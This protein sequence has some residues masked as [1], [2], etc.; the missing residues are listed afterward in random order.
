MWIGGLAE[1]QSLMGGLLGS[2]FEYVFRTQMEAL[3][4]GDRLYYLPRIEGTDYEESLQDSS[5]AQLIRANTGI[6]HLPG[7]IFTTPEYTIE[8]SNYYVKNADGSVKLDA[9]GNPT[10]LTKA[11]GS[12]DTTNWLK[13]P[14]TGKLMVTVDGT[15]T[16]VFLGDDNFLGN[17]IVLGG[18]AGNDKLTA[19]PSDADTVWGDGGNDV[20]DGG[21][22]ADFLFGGD[23]NDTLIGGQG[24]DTLH[25]D[26]GNDTIYGG[27][28]IDTIF[29]GDGN[30]YIE[31]GRGDDAIL[32]GLGNDIIIGNEG[33]DA[34]T[35]NEGDDWLE[36]RGGQGQLMFGDS[37]APTGQQPLYSG[38]DVMVGGIAGGDIMKGFSGDDIMLGHGSFTKFIGG[39]GFDWGSY[40]LATQGVDEDMN[41]KEFVAVNG[42]VDNVRDVWQATEGASGSAFNDNI[43]G[44]N[45]TKLLTTKDELDNVNLISGLAGFFDPGAVSFD[46]GNILL[47]GGGSDTLIGGGGN[48]II[49]G[50]AW[51]HV[52]LSSYSAG[53]TIIRQILQD[54]N[55]NTYQ[56]MEPFQ[57]TTDNNGLINNFV[58]GTIDATHHVN[59]LNVD[60][61]V[62]HGI[63]DNYTWAAGSFAEGGNDAEGFLTITQTAPTVVV[64]ANPQGVLGANDDT[65]RIRH[66]ERLQFSDETV[67]IDSYGNIISSSLIH[68]A[69][70]TQIANYE[71]VYGKYYDAVP[72]GTPTM[73][74][75]DPAG[76]PVDPTVAVVVG[77]TLHGSVSLI[78][79]LDNLMDAS[80]KVLTGPGVSDAI[81]NAHYQWQY[82]DAV[83]G[84]WVDYAGATSADFVVTPFLVL[85]ALGVRLKV[86]YVDG[87]G[88]TEQVFSDP[89]I[90]V[91]T[92]PAAGGNTA[93]FINAGTQFNGIGNTTAVAGSAFDFFTPL[94]SI[95]NDAQTTPDLLIY[96]A[97]LASGALLSTVGLQFG[98][99]PGVLA[100]PG[101]LGAPLAGEFST[102]PGATLNTVGPIA[103]RVKATD[104][105]G[106]SVTNTFTINVQ[107][108]NAAPVAVND[109]YTAF[110]SVA[111]TTL[112]S[113]GVLANDSDANQDPFTAILVNGPTHALTTGPG[114]FHLNA[115]GTF[116]YTSVSTF[117]GVDT[118]TYQDVDSVGAVGNIATVTINVLAFDLPPVVSA[119][120]ETTTTLEDTK[121]T[122]TL[123]PGTDVDGPVFAANGTTPILTYSI[124]AGSAT[125]GTVTLVAADGVTPVT[126]NTT[127]A[128]VFTPTPNY[129]TNTV[130]S[131]ISDALFG[132]P[133]T[134]QYLLNDNGTVGKF[135]QPKTVSVNV[136]PVNDGP[137]VLTLSGAVGRRA[138]TLTAILAWGPRGHRHRAGVHVAA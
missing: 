28:G 105:G 65:D 137:G 116:V 132:G 40:E 45:A 111:L 121:V 131:P 108:P 7:N 67:A 13:N 117:T 83:S 75:T 56:G 66:I 58:P 95:F 86:S 9:A 110:K 118:F 106:L 72:F 12:L 114:A 129:G 77:D 124:V 100:P 101:G 24:D 102:L 135:S 91:I 48:D 138:D 82:T 125:N 8:A 54:P 50:D 76:N 17:E 71:T 84:N 62:Y 21:G 29:G 1:K 31:G 96:T 3:Q 18:T 23:G 61:A 59:P 44:D 103:V 109:T 130:G 43:L 97:T 42:A 46:G 127:G 74:E 90:N 2:T 64:G 85:N 41:R 92:L 113:Q 136:T 134:F 10:F 22:G 123:L 47:G 32:G 120:A 99:L 19:G 104:A 98:T 11:D 133:G 33:F 69:S 35:G 73:T 27:D 53:G 34:L 119:L 15:G 5:L 68:F 55:G 57:F 87:K 51:L 36:S 63:R 25:G 37:G 81:T 79:D 78:S 6:Q 14:T 52:G 26:T 89:S 4:D 30:D 16:L 93:P 115:D 88:Y 128:Y 38:N 94:T 39:L 107:S 60:T 70:P 20:I 112:P 126:T 80:G 122:G 49:D